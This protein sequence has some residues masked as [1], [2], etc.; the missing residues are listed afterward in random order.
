[1]DVIPSFNVLSPR[2]MKQIVK[3]IFGLTLILATFLAGETYMSLPVSPEYFRSS[4]NMVNSGQSYEFIGV[5][6]NRAYLLRR[7][8]FSFRA[9]LGL[10]WSHNVVWCD[11]ESFTQEEQKALRLGRH[12]WLLQREQISGPYPGP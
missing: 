1:M 2:T 9:I 11:L 7:S 4:L 5:S 8:A 3:I 12:P 6:Q 10:G